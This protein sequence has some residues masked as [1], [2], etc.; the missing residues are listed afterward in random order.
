MRAAWLLA[1][2]LLVGCGPRDPGEGDGKD[3]ANAPR[4]P[5]P[6]AVQLDASGQPLPD[7]LAQTQLLRR[8]NSEEPGTLDPHRAEGVPAA[9]ILRDLFE[10]LVTTDPEGRLIPGAA[11]RWDISRDGLTYTFYLREDGAWSNGEPVTADDFVFSLRRS[12]DPDTATVHGRMLAPIANAD[13]ILAGRAAVET[14]AVTALNERSVQIRLTAPTPYFLGLLTHA[15]T[16]PVHRASLERHGSDFVQ[17]GKLVSNGAFELAE[18]NPRASMRLQRNPHYH[19]A[20]RV[21]I[22]EVV[23]YPIEDQNTE[24]QRFRAGDLDWTDQV[25][26]NQFRWIS[27]NLP[28]ALSVSPWFGSY[29][30]GFNLTRPPF[31]D[32]LALRQ[33]LTLAIDRDILTGKVTQFGEI[34]SFWLVPQGLPDYDG[35]EIEAAAWSQAKREQRARELYNEAGYSEDYPLEVELRYNTSENHR[36]IAV[37]MAAMWKQVLGVRTR[38]INEEFRVFLQN[39]ELKRRTEAFRFGWIGD[40]Q[41]PYTFLELFRSGH[42]RNDVGYAN[43][44]FDRLLEQIAAERIPARRRNLMREAERMLLADQVV[45]PVYTYVTKRLVDPLLKGWAPNVM[46]FHPSAQMFFVKAQSDATNIEA[47]EDKADDHPD[48]HPDDPSNA[49]R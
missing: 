26:H 1:L 2:P 23:Y 35:P 41:D 13:D 40:Y 47:I 28:A 7:V 15:A 36:K 25:P 11:G 17:P 33:A 43:P 32:N 19:A 6:V 29:F 20:G 39:R 18:W 24:F 3:P 30:Y 31:E 48:D 37:S 27:R 45:L 14:L 22:E 34:P 5:E 8:G 21:V 16:Y 44:T 12:V 46:D 9:N 38:L 49:E 10:G 42:R 4:L